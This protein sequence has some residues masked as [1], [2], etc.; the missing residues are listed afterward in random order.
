MALPTTPPPDRAR[1]LHPF[2][3]RRLG[4]G[5][6]AEV[7][8]TRWGL[9]TRE[10]SLVPYAR[11]QSV[12]VVQGPI[13][14][15]LRLATVYADTAG[16][17][18]AV[19]KDRDLAEAWALADELARRARRARGPAPLI[20]NE[21]ADPAAVPAPLIT[22]EVADP[23]AVPAPAVPP[24]AERAADGGPARGAAVPEDDAFWRRPPGA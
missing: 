18:A 4:V 19:A 15:R 22:N 20:T 5:L 16:G 2:A 21:V 6:T 13:Q 9:L 10:L 1:W 7:I 3:L 12:R 14:R 8:V 23:A 17:R 11:L 24:P